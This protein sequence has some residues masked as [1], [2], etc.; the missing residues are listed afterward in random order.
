MV[1]IDYGLNLNIN[2]LIHISKVNSGKTE[3]V[4]A[5]CKNILIA[6]KG[7]VKEHYFRHINNNKCLDA[8][9]TTLHLFLK[10]IILEN[11]LIYINN[12]K[13]EFKIVEQEKNFKL[14]KPDIYAINNF[15]IPII[16][17]FAVTHRVGEEKLLLIKKTGILAYEIVV[18]PNILLN[19]VKN[20]LI[21]NIN[22]SGVFIKC[23]Y[24]DNLVFFNN[25]ISDL[26]YKIYEF[27]SE[28][29]TK[30]Q[31]Q[32]CDICGKKFRCLMFLS[33]YFYNTW[34]YNSNNVE[35]DKEYNTL[36]ICE[37]CQTLSDK[38]I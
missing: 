6:C 1:E 2:K 35:Y 5:E 20:H 17:E 18:F 27:E 16:L 37:R 12:I 9:E 28:V 4:C 32:I 7:K 38:S 30:Y 8:Y 29:K 3:L 26:T 25:K 11:K 33:N 15:G 23:L 22:C 31:I 10:Q 19:D 21:N 13:Y 36:L 14:F 34:N 24:N